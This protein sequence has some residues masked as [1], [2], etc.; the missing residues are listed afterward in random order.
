MKNHKFIVDVF[1]KYHVKNP[2]SVLLLVGEGS[3]FNE[4]K[5]QVID[6]GLTDSVIFAGLRTDVEKIYAAIDLFLLP[7]LFEGLP[8][9]LVEA[10]CSG[11]N[12][13]VSDS[14]T[15]EAF[16]TDLVTSLKLKDD[17]EVWVD[18]LDKLSAIKKDRSLY[19]ELIRKK[20]YDI[21]YTATRLTEIYTE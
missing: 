15:R 19:A 9:V 21:R 13:L 14:I 12:C 4:V 7:S 3:L 1:H 2:K 5:H 17:I 11:V 8:F 16:I 10:Q 20:K 6:L 18:A